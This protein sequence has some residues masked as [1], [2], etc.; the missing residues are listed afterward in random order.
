MTKELK[1]TKFIY[2]IVVRV[3]SNR[4]STT[5]STSIRVH[6]DNWD[7]ERSMVKHNHPKGQILNQQLLEFYNKV[8]RVII[9]LQDKNEFSF[10]SLK[11]VLENKNHANYLGGPPGKQLN[12]TFCLLR[13]PR[14]SGANVKQ[15]SISNAPKNCSW[16][17]VRLPNYKNT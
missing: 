16:I 11:N 12:Q 8:Q 9:K 1:Q 7:I 3:T 15:N 6:F 13:K 17:R 14:D 10:E 2:P 4:I 5:V